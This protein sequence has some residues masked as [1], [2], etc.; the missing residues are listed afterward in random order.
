ML[1]NISAKLD[2]QLAKIQGQ[3]SDEEF[4]RYRRGF[5]QVLGHM[6]TEIQNSLYVEIRSSSWRNSEAPIG[7]PPSIYE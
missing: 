5:G 6:L 1:L 2:T 3:C 4:Q 7:V